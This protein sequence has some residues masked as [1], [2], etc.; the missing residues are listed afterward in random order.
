MSEG[1]RESQIIQTA[2]QILIEPVLRL[3]Q[4]DPHQWSTRPCS[5]CRAV[6]SLV[7]K[8]FGCILYAKENPKR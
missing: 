7:G 3:L 6:S 2:V 8:A 1:T 5:T 4:V